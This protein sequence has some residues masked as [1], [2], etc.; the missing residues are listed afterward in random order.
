[1]KLMIKEKGRLEKGLL[2]HALLAFLLQSLASMM[3]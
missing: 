3:H 2:S 1:M